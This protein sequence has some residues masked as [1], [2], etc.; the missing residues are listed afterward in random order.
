MQRS[1]ISPA[2]ALRDLAPFAG[3]GWLAWTSRLVRASLIPS[4]SGDACGR[5]VGSGVPALVAMRAGKRSRWSAVGASLIFLMAAGLLRSSAGGMAS[6]AG[7]LSLIPV[8]YI[9]LHGRSRIELLLVLV[10]LALFYM[11]P[12]SIV[13][14][15]AYPHLQYRAALLAVSVSSIIGLATQRLVARA[16]EQARAARS[17]E[18]MLEQVTAVAHGLFDST[19][20]RRDVCH[21]AT[22]ISQATAAVLYEPI[23]DGHGL[24]ATASAGFLL[25]PA[26]AS[27]ALNSAVQEAFA[28]GQAI[29]VTEEVE[30]RVGSVAVWIA[31][32]RPS[33]ILYQPLVRDEVVVGVLVVGWPVATQADR[34]RAGMMGLVA[35]QAAAAISRFD[36]MHDLTGAALS[37][38]LTGLPNRRAWQAGLARAAAGQQQWAIAM[39]DLDH[40]KQFNDRHGHLAGDRLLI[41]TATA[42]RALLGPG[43]IL[44]RVGGEEFALLLLDCDASSALRVVDRL[45]SAVTHGQTGSAGIALRHADEAH[46]AVI[47]RADRA[48]Y[49]A[50]AR[51]RDRSCLAAPPHPA[52][53]PQPGRGP[54]SASGTR[55]TGPKHERAALDVVVDGV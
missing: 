19:D 26:A 32:G 52:A 49:E 41:E 31:S 9:A 11:L 2:R 43:D 21:A 4:L 39:L 15:H 54:A 40:F 20:V 16:R 22:T 35:Q 27:A 5:A 6:G 1:R 45:R 42:W 50:K 53:G 38:P 48:L 7:I 28:S 44:A 18:R 37:D 51:G 36:E 10:G 34:L 33:A 55:R 8:F 12:I 17:N 3:A 23:Q 25:D 14:G 29:L 24:G 46:E 47:A 30:S 13:G